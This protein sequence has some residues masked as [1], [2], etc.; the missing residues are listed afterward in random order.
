MREDDGFCE[1]VK[2]FRLAR[3]WTIRQMSE[4]AK[5]SHT[6]IWTIERGWAPTPLTRA[7]I[8]KALPELGKQ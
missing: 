2:A 3:L 7:R 4:A 5:V 1:Q 8:L 6:T